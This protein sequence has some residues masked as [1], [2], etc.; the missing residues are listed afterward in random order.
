MTSIRTAALALLAVFLLALTLSAA[1]PF[2]TARN[3]PTSL[4]NMLY[5]AGQDETVT[6]DGHTYDSTLS[7]PAK[8][9]FTWVSD[10][11]LTWTTSLCTYYVTTGWSGSYSFMVHHAGYTLQ[12]SKAGYVNYGNYY[13]LLG[14]MTIYIPMAESP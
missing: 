8:N 14:D 7:D 12:A 3:R 2:H 5:C 1:T 6:V 9:E 4:N 13:N 10:V 11:S